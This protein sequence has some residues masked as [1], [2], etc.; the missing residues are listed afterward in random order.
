MAR[1]SGTKVDGDKLQLHE[2]DPPHHRQGHYYRRCG[3]TPRVPDG[4]RS[5]GTGAASPGAP[6][7]Q[8]WRL[9]ERLRRRAEVGEGETIGRSVR[10]VGARKGADGIEREVHAA[11]ARARR[12]AGAGPSGSSTANSSS[13]TSTRISGWSRSTARCSPGRPEMNEQESYAPP[14]LVSDIDNRVS[15]GFAATSR[16]LPLLWDSIWLSA[17]DG[18]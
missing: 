9:F 12:N 17:L 1:H 2:N 7:A 18:A 11:V 15:S 16:G 3:F 8:T 13:T 5:T 10:R 6:P 14:R 4:R